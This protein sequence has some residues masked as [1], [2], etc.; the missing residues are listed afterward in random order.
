[1]VHR[2]RVSKKTWE[3]SDEFDVVFL[4]ITIVILDFIIISAI[5]YFYENGMAGY[6]DV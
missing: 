2:Y 3:F 5:V 1:M 4:W 6:K